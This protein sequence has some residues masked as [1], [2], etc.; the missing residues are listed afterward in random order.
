MSKFSAQKIKTS[1]NTCGLSDLCLPAGLEQSDMDKLEESVNR[2]R[3]IH[4]GDVI[5]EMGNKFDSV[6]AIRSGT[7]KLIRLTE[8]GDEQIIGFYL[9]GE[10][11]G[12]DA[13]ENG[14]Y[15][16]TAV[17]METLTYCAFPFDRLATLS[18][19][20]PGLQ[21]QIFRLM[22]KELSSENEMLLSICNKNAEARVATFLISLSQRFQNLGY[23]S[24]EFNLS[25]SRQEIATYL[26]L[27]METVS[28]IISKFQKQGILKT[29]RKMVTISENERLHQICNGTA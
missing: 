11:L 4:K 26:G 28:R 7:A 27:T 19:V 6:Y 3:P 10:L 17:A 16:C 29:E 2:S 23:S 25:M 8:T 13:I 15:K 5:F 21:Q 22:S 9:P 20:I 24:S 18:Q 1:C 12:L 14:Q